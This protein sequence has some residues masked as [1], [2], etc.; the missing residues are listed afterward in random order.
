MLGF[1]RGQDPFS[2]KFYQCSILLDDCKHE[3]CFGSSRA[4]FSGRTD[5]EDEAPT[6]RSSDVKSQLI[7]RGP[8]TGKDSWQKERNQR[9]EMVRWHHRLIGHELEETPQNSERQ[10]CLFCCHTCNHKMSDMTQKLNNTN[11]N[12]RSSE[13][14][15][16]GRSGERF[17]WMGR[18][19]ILWCMSLNPRQGAQDIECVTK[20]CFLKKQETFFFFSGVRAL[21]ECVL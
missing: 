1:P 12:R 19:P 14:S 6:L 17:R 18:L 2:I 16:P 10:G 9:D 4:I 5:A 7:V 15:G 20:H 8:D 21:T 3:F 11:E 13:A